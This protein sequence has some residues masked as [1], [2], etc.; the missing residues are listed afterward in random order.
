MADSEYAYET[1]TNENDARECARL[2]AEEFCAHNP[3]TCFDQISSECFYD[4]CSWPLMK[5]MLVEH[6]SLLARHRSTG[7]IIGATIAGDFFLEY[8]RKHLRDISNLSSTIAIDNLLDEMDDLFV[9]RDFGQELQ[10]NMV[11]HVPLCA[12][13][14]QHGGKGIVTRMIQNVCDNARQKQGFQYLLGQTTHQ[15]TRHVWIK[16]LGGKEVTIVDPT[17]WIWKKN[18]KDSS[19]P[20]KDYEGGSIPNIL[21]KL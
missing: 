18:G 7:E 8:Q 12:V 17:T 1:V 21:V 16:N 20:Y 15:A 5:D 6:L 10:S 13:R 2:I 19:C 9:T 3:I 14:S 4:Q 11:L